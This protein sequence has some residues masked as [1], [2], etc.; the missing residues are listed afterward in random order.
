[1]VHPGMGLPGMGLLGTGHPDM[2]LPG[3]QAC[4]VSVPGVHHQEEEE[5]VQIHQLPEGLRALEAL[6]GIVVGVL[7]T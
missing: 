1:M 6:P 2:V 3:M 7:E 5:E 4:P